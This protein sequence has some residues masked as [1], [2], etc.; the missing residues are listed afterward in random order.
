MTLNV[1]VQRKKGLPAAGLSRNDFSIYDEGRKQEIAYF[2]GP[3]AQETAKPFAQ[4]SPDVYS[5]LGVG[6][7]PRGITIILVDWL[8]MELF[9]RDRAR[10]AVIRFLREVPPDSRVAIYMLGMHLTILHDFITNVA[11]LVAALHKRTGG[12]SHETESTTRARLP[13]SAAAALSLT[14]LRRIEAGIDRTNGMQESYF[15]S[16]RL[17]I[18]LRALDQIGQR[19]AGA[20]GRKN[21]I[22]LTGRLPFCLCGTDQTD[23]R[24][25]SL[26][27]VRATERFLASVNLAVYPIDARGVIARQLGNWGQNNGAPP[28]V[29]QASPTMRTAMEEVAKVTGG[30]AYYD[31]NDIMAAIHR[32]SKDADDTYILGYYPSRVKWNGKFRKVKVKVDRRGFRVRTQTGYYAVPTLPAQPGN[33]AQIATEPLEETAIPM[34]VKVVPGQTGKQ[35]RI[36][37]LINLDPRNIRFANSA[38]GQVAALAVGFFEE[39]AD[40]R[41]VGFDAGNFNLPARGAPGKQTEDEPLVFPKPVS[42]PLLPAAAR[43]VLVVHDEATGVSG[44]ISIPLEN[45]QQQPAR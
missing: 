22:W 29:P 43:L 26:R 12:F 11:S 32:A 4:G 27:A 40:G 39:S 33:L 28:I 17:E 10:D 16:N 36:T 3:S 6:G 7:A 42:L 15:R 21:L 31:T 24:P 2:E 9:T 34:A 8:N 37:L 5:N 38:G 14:V 20:P 25:T 23:L 19:V 35:R 18:T 1:V 13:A 45:Y 41:I 30:T 44:S